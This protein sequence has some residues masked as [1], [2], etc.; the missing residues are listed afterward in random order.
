[1][2][3]AR[4]LKRVFDIDIEHCPDCGGALKTIAA[5]EDPP[6]I[7]KILGHLG[8]PTRALG[9]PRLG[10]DNGRGQPDCRN[11]S[12]EEASPEDQQ[13]WAGRNTHHLLAAPPLAWKAAPST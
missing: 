1:M 5:I 9:M 4:L 11:L 12:D 8:L 13:T 6:V 2:A 3:W 7:D 10:D